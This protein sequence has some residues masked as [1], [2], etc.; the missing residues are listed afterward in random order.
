MHLTPMARSFT[1]YGGRLTLARSQLDEEAWSAAWAEGLSVGAG[2]EL[3]VQTSLGVLKDAAPVSYQRIGGERV[4][5]E[6]RYTLKGDG[7][8]GF[9]VGSYDPR[10]PL[11]IDPG[12]AY[13]TF[14]GGGSFDEGSDIAVLDGR[15]YVTGS[16]SS[17]NY[18]TTT[19]A[20]DT[21]LDGF[22]DTFV[23]KLNASDSALAYSTYLG[24]TGDD[25]GESIAVDG[26]GRAFVTGT[27]SSTDYPKTSGAFDRTSNGD[28]DAFVTKFN[29]SGSA[30]VYSTFLGGTDG[31]GASDIAVGGSGR[32]CVTGS[33][34]GVEVSSDFPTTPGAFDTTFGPSSNTFSSDAFVTK[35]PTG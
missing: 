25:E 31:D 3:L 12:L 6:S 21:S 10:Y 35:L 4:P 15:A 23:T 14:L 34:E 26:S 5:V 16:T 2:G 33:T 28:V 19:G 1:D 22:S 11:V 20:F 29:A 8:Y 32:A 24:G 7:G 9:A 27:T 30:L 13:S 18:P 17:T